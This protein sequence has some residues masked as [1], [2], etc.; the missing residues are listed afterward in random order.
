MDG[1]WLVSVAVVITGIALMSGAIFFANALAPPR[2]PD[3]RLM[4][5]FP[6]SSA[7]TTAGSMV[8]DSNKGAMIRTAIPVENIKIWPENLLNC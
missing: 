2:C 8:F 3:M 6:L 4:A 7:T 1:S 5:W